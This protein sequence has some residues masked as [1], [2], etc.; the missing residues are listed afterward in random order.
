MQESKSTKLKT[1]NEMNKNY[2]LT[3][4]SAYVSFFNQAAVITLIPLLFIPIRE[5]LGLSY[6][7]LATLVS[8]NFIVQLITDLVLSRVADKYGF[9]SFLLLSEALIF[10]GFIIFSLS[11]DIFA[12]PYQG[13]V[14]GTIFFSIGGGLGEILIS[15]LI[16]SLPAKSKRGSMAFLHSVYGI[17]QM[18][19]IIITSLSIH[20]AGTRYWRII[21]ACWAL[22]PLINF[23]M[24]LKARFPKPRSKSITVTKIG[25]DLFKPQFVLCM[26]IIFFGAGVENTMVQWSSAYMER[27]MALPKLFGDSLGILMFAL[28]LSLCRILFG[29]SGNKINLSGAM[30]VFSVCCVFCYAAIALT[31]IPAVALTACALTGFF[32]AMLWPGSLL[33]ANESL[34]HSGAWIFAFLAF[35]GDFGAAF[36]PWFAGLLSDR[37]DKIP[38]LV[39]IAEGFTLT[40]EQLGM[41]SGM[42]LSML[43]PLLTAFF[44][45]LYIRSRKKSGEILS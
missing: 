15:P 4:A 12:K 8:I 41:R 25:Q 3:R 36:C 11:P 37:A 18:L 22:M 33:L 13:F 7:S 45:C 20:I 23:F 31:S 10:V 6:L 34:P 1:K 19:V 26:L 5:D 17:G 28:M 39:N 21:I 16:N 38:V 27:A 40:N 44:I 42:A 29:I 14:I 30:L 35:S 2:A 43:Y 32:S 9:K 24:Y